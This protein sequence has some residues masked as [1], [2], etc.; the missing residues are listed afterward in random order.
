MVTI[1]YFKCDSTSAL[2]LIQLIIGLNTNNLHKV[3]L[4]SYS[5]YAHQPERHELIL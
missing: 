5:Q 1:M 2:K 4:M 3:R